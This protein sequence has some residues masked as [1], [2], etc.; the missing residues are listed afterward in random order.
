M[1][2]A[3]TLYEAMYLLA[4]DAE[5][6]E[7]A[8]IAG[9]LKSTVEAVGGEVV[10]D[11]LFGRRRLA[12]E[13][14]NYRDGI[15]RI[16]YFNGTGAVVQALNND[17][18]LNERIIRGRA[19]VAN[20]AAIFRSRREE[21]GRAQELAEQAEGLGQEEELAVVAPAA[22]SESSEQ[23]P[24]AVG[25]EEE[26]LAVENEI[27]EELTESPAEA[28]EAEEEPGPTAEESEAEAAHPQAES[29]E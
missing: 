7:M 9:A 13:I 10:A 5:D 8:E 11:E 12:Y 14:N 21:E 18:G 24:E 26:A 28:P 22:A 6:E 16:L 23:P 1:G 3:L 15:Y 27:G 29:D 20:P 4:P 19:V 2:N 25:E 17:F